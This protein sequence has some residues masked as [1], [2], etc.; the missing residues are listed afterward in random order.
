MPSYLNKYTAEFVGTAALVML[1]CGAVV[2]SGLGQGVPSGI[3][4]VALVFGLAVAGLAYGLG[5]ISGCHIN[6][7]VT[8]S[9]W[10]A[11]RISTSVVPGYIAAQL[12]GGVFGAAILS[13]MLAGK[14]AGY[15][16]S[17][18][19]LGQNG[20]GEGY[21]GGYGVGAAF[22]A[23]A[24]GTFIYA[25]VILGATAK[26]GSTA[27]AGLAIGAT[28]VGLIITFINVSGASVNPARSLGPAI[29]VGG[30]ALSQL[31]LFFVAPILGG[32]LA[33][34]MFREKEIEAR[35]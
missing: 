4:Q 29:F 10:V 35:A 17:V 32:V 19:G 13:W 12:A 34:I 27:A 2:F 18:A 11:G 24:L 3:L 23:E 31:W 30:K 16:V 20:W 28:L 21:L 8:I 22:A 1:G 25:V 26:K 5:P 6:P 15:D 9:A 14:L 33:G 7:A